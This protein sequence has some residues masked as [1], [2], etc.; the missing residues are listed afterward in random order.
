[1]CEKYPE[2]TTARGDYWET[3]DSEVKVF[4]IDDGERHWY[5]A[6]SFVDALTEHYDLLGPGCDQE[7]DATTITLEIIP[8]EERLTRTENEG[9]DSG[10]E[11]RPFPPCFVTTEEPDQFPT[12]TSTAAEWAA[13]Y[14]DIAPTQIMSSVF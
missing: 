8:G 7:V 11:D 10:L 2:D 3:T 1:M 5:V 13:Y 12:R 14:R 6:K 9:L 4:K